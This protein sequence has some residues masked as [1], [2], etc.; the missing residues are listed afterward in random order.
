MHRPQSFVCYC[1]ALLLLLVQPGSAIKLKFKHEECMTYTFVQYEY[2]Y[3]S[4]IALPDVYG[5]V[6]YYDLVITAPSGIKLY[7]V[8]GEQDATFHLVPTEEGEHRFCIKFNQA[9]SETRYYN[10]PR[11]IQ[12]T[13][14]VGYEEAHGKVQESDTQYIWHYIYQ[15]DHQLSELRSQVHF[16]HWREKRHRLTVE[17]TNRRLIF[18]AIVRSVTLIAVSVG[19][20]MVWRYLFSK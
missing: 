5:V 20:V 7:E 17:S 16:L 18:Y 14:N 3:G 9:K 6:A 15:L 10:I 4:F 1:F 19:Q 12:W 11:D 2:F 8:Y 13:L